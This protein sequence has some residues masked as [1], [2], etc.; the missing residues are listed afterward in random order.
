MRRTGSVFGKS[1]AFEVRHLGPIL[2][3][4][5]KA[6]QL[7]SIIFFFL[8]YKNGDDSDYDSYNN[9]SYTSSIKLFLYVQGLCGATKKEH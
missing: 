4:Q 8:I 2:V 7:P 9:T 1:T 6:T 5:A 3:I